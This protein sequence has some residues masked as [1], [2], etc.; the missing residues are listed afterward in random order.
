MESIK[1]AVNKMPKTNDENL[2]VMSLEEL[3]KLVLSMRVFHS[4]Q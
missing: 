2:K 1:W 4:T 3:K